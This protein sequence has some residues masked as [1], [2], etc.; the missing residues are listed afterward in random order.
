[1]R[2]FTPVPRSGFLRVF[3]ASLLSFAILVMPFAPV[4][5]AYGNETLAAANSGVEIGG[6][7]EP[8]EPSSNNSAS[9]LFVALPAP[10]LPAPVSATKSGTIVDTNG[11]GNLDPGEKIDYV[12]TLG[13]TSG[14]D[15]T[16][17]VF[18]DT[19]DIH[20][21]LFGTWNSSPLALS[22]TYNAE[23]GVQLVQAAPGVRAN[24]FDPD[25]GNNSG[26]TVTALLDNGGNVIDATAPFTGA[27]AQ[28][29]TV[30]LNADGSFNYTSAVNFEGND[31]FKYRLS[32]GTA[33]DTGTVT[34]KVDKPP[35][36]T[37]TVPANS[38]IN[39]AENANITVN[40]SESVNASVSSF[41]LECPTGTAKT[42]TVS[43]SGTSAITLDPTVDLPPGVICSVTVLANQI[44]DT[45]P[46]DPPDNMAA[47][48]PFSFGVKP[49]AVDD[50]RSATGNI[51]INTAGSG[52]SVLSNDLPVGISVT[53]SDSTS[54]RGGNVTVN[55]NGT[56]TYNPP[57]GYTGADTFNYTIS[58]AAGSDVGTVT[59]NISDMIWFIDD[60]AAACTTISAAAGCGRR[61]NPL[62]TLAAFEAANGN[63]DVPASN[64]YNPAA[65]DHIFIYNGSYPA[66][67]TLENNQRV[68][69]E[70]ATSSLATLTGITL[71]TDSDALPSTGGTKPTIT[72]G[73]NGFNLAQDNQFYGF[74]FSNTTGTAVN[75]NGA[76]GTLIFGDIVINNT[77]NTSGSGISLINGGAGNVT[78]TGINTINTAVATALLVL[79]TNIGSGNLTFRRIDAGN[80]TGD[81]DPV[82]GIQLSS[83]GTT[84]G[85]HGGLI[86]TGSTA[87]NCG[88]V[89]SNPGGGTAATVTAPVSGDC[90][91]G[92]IQGTSGFGISLN[93][94]RGVSL[95]RMWVKSNGDDGI[96]GTTVTDFSLI[97][98]L[99]ESNGNIVNEHGIDMVGLF[100]NAAITN[101]TVRISAENN[102]F[103]DNTSGTLTLLDITGSQF[104]STTA[105]APGADGVLIKPQGTS[106]VTVNV[107]NCFFSNNRDDQ[108]QMAP[109]GTATSKI[110]VNNNTFADSTATTLGGGITINP[111]ANTQTRAIVTN[112]DMTGAVLSAL[113]FN[114]GVGSAVTS[115]FHVTAT[116]NFI[117]NVGVV[118]SGSETGHGI[119]VWGNGSGI[120]NAVVSNNDVRNWGSF[121]GINVAHQDG[122]GDINVTMKDNTV[123]EKSVNTLD[124]IRIEV[125]AVS[126]G[127]IPDA[128]TICADIGDAS[129]ALKN[130]ITTEPNAN[131]DDLRIRIRQAANMTFPGY[132]G[133]ATDAA[134]LQ[135]YLSGRNTLTTVQATTSSTHPTPF[136]NAGAGCT[137]PLTS[138]ENP[139]MIRRGGD[140]AKADVESEDKII[141]SLA[142]GNIVSAVFASVLDNLNRDTQSAPAQN[143]TQPSLLT[144]EAA[145]VHDNT[146][147]GADLNIAPVVQTADT[148]ATQARVWNDIV[149][150]P[151]RAA[152]ASD[153]TSVNA[154][155]TASSQYQASIVKASYAPPANEASIGEKA[156]TLSER[157]L[158]HGKKLRNKQPNNSAAAASVFAPLPSGE[159][160]T[161]NGAGSGFTLPDGKSV[162]ITFQVTLNEPPALS[163][164][165]PPQ[166]SNFGSITCTAGCSPTNTNTVN[167]PVDRYNSSTSV[168]SSSPASFTVD[169]IILTAT[170]VNANV[171]PNPLPPG[172]TTP[173]GTVTFK[174][175][176][177][178]IPNCSNRPMSGG[179]A[180]CNVPAL[181]LAAGTHPITADYSGDGNFDPVT[182]A[183]FNQ[184]VTAC[185]NSITVMNN[186][187]NAVPPVGSLRE[188]ITNICPGGT[189]SFDAAVTGQIN[190]VAALPDL[191]K[192][193]TIAGPGANVLEVR[194]S[195][196]GAGYRVFNISSGVTVNISGL[197]ISNG[198][199][200]L[201]GG[202]INNAGTLNLSN[203]TVKG[204]L[205]TG[206]GAG[207]N[208][209]GT[210]NI[211]GST[212]SNN[213]AT[214]SGGGILNSATGILTLKN[215]T[216]STN[217]SNGGANTGGGISNAGTATLINVTVAANTLGGGINS[218]GT[219][220]L[221]N[222]LIADNTTGS[223]ADIN[224]VFNSNDYNLI[225]NKG[226]ATFTGT[227]AHDQVGTSGA[228]LDAK[229]GPLF[230]NGGP[231]LTHAL[232]TG[233]PAIEAGLNSAATGASLSTD[234]RG[235]GY[236][237]I[238]DSADN[239][240]TQTV[241]IGAFELHPSVE[242][243]P[244]QSAAEDST[245]AI[246]FNVGDDAIGITSVVVTS[247]NTA[248]VLSDNA[249]LTISGAGATRT[250]TITPNAN[251]NSVANGGPTT[252]TVTVTATNGRTAIDTF[253]LTITEVNDAPTAV[254]EAVSNIGEDSG[255]YSIPIATLLGNDSVGP[256]NEAGQTLSIQSVG[257]A[258]GGTVAIN[259]AN[260]EFTPTAN[261][262]GAAGFD[263]VIQDNG[264][265]SGGP[266]AKQD[267]G[268]AT[269]NI[270]A[271]NDTPSF[272]IGA[273]QTV[274]EDA[275][276]QSVSGWATNVTAGAPDE[277]GT[278]T[279]TF[280]VT[281]NTN[282]ALFSTQ[283]A[284]DSSG[285]LTYTPA[286]D[287]SGFADITLTLS[288]NGGGANTSAPQTFKITVTADNDAPSL[289]NNTGITVNEGSTG[290]TIGSAELEV[291]DVDNTAAQLTYTIGTPP[292][293]GTLKK[294]GGALAGGSTFT[295]DD[296][297]NN[298]ITYDHDGSE[299]T[300]DSFTFTVSDG[301]GGSVGG[302]FSITV[303]P[304]NDTPVLAA[305]TVLAIGTGATGTVSNTLLS[306]T[307][308]DNTAAEIT[309][310]VG[311]LP[312]H[313]TL[314]N[315]GVVL[316]GGGT[317]TQADV[318]NNLITY[319]HNG[320]AATTDSF[321]FTADDTDSGDGSIASTT[322]NINLNCAATTVV[323]NTGNSGTGSLREAIA[324][325]C[326]G[327]T[328]TF[329]LDSNIDPGYDAGTNTFTIKLASELV[330]NK[331]LTITGPTASRVIISGEGVTRVFN[332]S[333]GATVAISNLT[334]AN[335]Q[336]NAGGG[337]YNLGNLTISNST[338]TGNKAVGPGAEGGAID[339]EGGTLTIRNSTISGNT[340]EGDGGGVL[341][342]GTSN[343]VLTNVTITNN[344]ANNDN[345]SPGAGGGLAQVSAPPTKVTLKNTIIAGNF[346]GS[347][348]STPDDIYVSPLLGGSILDTSASSN[349]LVGDAATS[350]GLPD[351]SVDAA[352]ANI[353]GNNGAGTINISTVLNTTLAF[354][355]GPTKTHLLAPG[356]PAINAGNNCVL[357]NACTPPPG[358]NLTTDQRGTGFPRNVGTVDIGAVEV[359]YAVSATAGTPQS[360]APNAAFSTQLK[361][362]VTESGNPQ[363]NVS[364]TFTAPAS[365]AS[366]TFPGNVTTTTVS[367]NASGEATAPVFT[368]NG[369]AGGPYNV[370]ASLAGGSP[371]ANFALT[372]SKQPAQVNLSNLVQTFDGLPKPVTVTT[373]PAGLSVVVTYDGSTTVPT[374]FKSGGY[375]VVATVTDP[376]FEGSASATL[377]I[378]KASSTTTISSGNAVY[379]GNP[380]GASAVVTGVGGLNQSLTVTYTGIN[381]TTY[382]PS[383]TAP[384][385]AGEYSA[386]ASFAG[387]TNHLGS[388]D[389]KNYSIVKAGQT[390]NFGALSNK[391]F[392]DADFTV[393]ATASSN[394]AV[395]FGAS[396]QCTV[397][398][399]TVHLT[400]GGSCTIT[401]SQ[402]GN[403]NFNQATNIPQTFQIGAAA[404]TTSVSSSANPSGTGQNVTF[405]ATV[406]SAAGTP[407]GTVQFKVDGTNTGAP[408]ALNASG[409]ATFSIDSLTVGTHAITAD[410]IGNA[411]FTASSG[412]LA[413]GQVVNINTSISINDVSLT[414]GDSGT[415]NFDFTVTLS[416]A[417]NL[418]VKVDFA[419]A[420]G[421]ATVAGSDYQSTTGTLTFIPGD[422]TKT[423]TVQV[424]GDTANEPNET[425]SVNLT[426][427][428][429]TTISDNQGLGTILNDDAP[430]VQF[431]TNTYNV[432]EGI[433]TGFA[434]LT[435][436]RTGD[437]SQALTVDYQ[438]SDQSG[439][440]PC[441]TNNNGFASDRC[442][443]GTA[444][445]TLR[446]AAGEA[447]KTIPV[448]IIN[449]AYV[450]PTEQLTIKLTNPTGGTLGSVDTATLNITDNDTQVATTNPIDDLDFFI[451]MQYADFLGR[452]PDP[453]GFAFWKA[454][455]T[456]NCPA[457]QTCD[458]IDTA[459]RFFGSDEFRE[460]GYFIYL[461]YHA[462]LGRRPTYAEWTMD[463]SKL[464]GYKTVQE[465]EAAKDAFIQEF[466]SRQEFMNL[467]NGSQ[468]GQTFVDTLIQKSGIT[469]ASKQSLINNYA[470][471]GRAATLRAFLETPEV[472]AA[473][474]DR[475]FVTM[476]YFGFL[477]RDAEAGGFAFW[478][479]KLNDSNR[480]YRLLV[481]GFI[482]SDEYRFRYAQISAP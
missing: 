372:N 468:T 19:I 393:S 98:S 270:T 367:T 108:L 167:T 153:E 470:T 47:N 400:G 14:S 414:E 188:A 448:V 160:V 216:I 283:P 369:T 27:S 161:V 70:G 130:T 42:F 139:F 421:T 222:T 59:I 93:S 44:T 1:M 200:A 420:N 317:F 183:I 111:V 90:S 374:S 94:T 83:T 429:N 228:P 351:K 314:F 43:G 419:T 275:G 462:A 50:A 105:A 243:I 191:G 245:P 193:L 406:A 146:A 221:S 223:D 86:V 364:V 32:D 476:L 463:V 435:V 264:T 89:V 385:N 11:D 173:G 390:I 101:S 396:G 209:T 315:N 190:L 195:Q 340:S 357:T 58:N 430:G 238:A 184:Q 257:N 163:Q 265:T 457:G 312:A 474:V 450:E 333:T 54:V 211:T 309:Y 316:A 215:S 263:Y 338:F 324:S 350:G 158:S 168:S 170:V 427:P 229:I 75:R 345:L 259:G 154:G 48:Y 118:Q 197:T 126:P 81:P 187:D 88:G 363:N 455:M 194:G 253:D 198:N 22:D 234:Q 346:T 149:P 356:S 434:T 135:T 53:A 285:K 331:N 387:D 342:C 481:G 276:P 466:M 424:N 217:T 40:F 226:T 124:G 261:F 63:A 120:I 360:A 74:T 25:N 7:V 405:T 15:A 322:F 102:L 206:A 399:N 446:F 115:T 145:I 66:P 148:N 132:I 392:G 332:I 313:G 56:F 49:R 472:Q 397:S 288:D 292:A 205:T 282:T 133:G 411:S 159:T 151:L 251:A 140:L 127:G 287:A 262:N 341:N 395:S 274:I 296:V 125:G 479:Q 30:T 304:V 480:D 201:G 230:N 250:L 91:G 440:T 254:D 465:Q 452:V 300:S 344:R 469:P 439:A 8:T 99:V 278:Q 402:G 380:Q 180:T 31:T 478:M 231:T 186:S 291:T 471:V 28:A 6:K 71:A 55:A 310:T 297:N 459:L 3:T 214:A 416:Q 410:Y 60:S 26:V 441:Q 447:S 169:P 438:T 266:D 73:G 189:I 141:A 165:S 29:G 348:G 179:Q 119:Q 376:A 87:G 248:L 409:V 418:T 428:D 249:H 320:D 301:A 235:P 407:T 412:T 343:A 232:L 444:S 67:L 359:S 36:V 182:S 247:S 267:T 33:T 327:N 35:S 69:G 196:A 192:T 365:G 467:Y 97:S 166:V 475:A 432:N 46:N 299:T 240:D 384:T 185:Q 347:S 213:V 370:T 308:A 218:T 358:A 136:G 378:N 176:G 227:T 106:N 311:T 388:S 237:R 401:A 82:N 353:I 104:S 473:F 110:T 303:T 286:A 460:R 37:T 109:T 21:T 289:V 433:N 329:T 156:E 181:A 123:A 220:N 373:V 103:V 202:G 277:D 306:V 271:V 386:S 284:V 138:L 114:L 256:A 117:G 269:F 305:N 2:R 17:V 426:N 404:S 449:D 78:N 92:T 112:N 268:R 371:S 175:N 294:S 330:I 258:T 337:I 128:G 38:A 225:E 199:D 290:T 164:T 9:P 107:S 210:L 280:N 76:I 144:A 295:Q 80:L 96:H 318:D 389:S 100:G 10:P 436:N 5:A 279:I 13:N 377:T 152:I 362:T 319:T 65:G 79:N 443:Y 116:G 207:I 157:S 442:D 85:T 219:T 177:V 45:D 361:A 422:L 246:I 142:N 383:T 352:R 12:V 445:G 451:F 334:I 328:I 382:G 68:I 51:R 171:A 61:T 335:G 323:T 408:V 208:N 72:S 398:G 255:V 233:S 293:K 212:I 147:S 150:A 354:N 366:G 239:S 24:D 302:T 57:P 273:D 260:V 461:F 456:N 204:N 241:D 403:S 437:I 95:T 391:T 336:S 178:A 458:R 252:I 326:P 355:G 394:L 174:D 172:G 381:G 143:N 77:S 113:N 413:G 122:N 339:S 23:T 62:S 52:F 4:A 121:Y 84:P 34:I 321:T 281:N 375:A 41:Q 203:S 18:N 482:N 20:T 64:I 464:N 454:R 162:T 236:P 477:R 224:G 431:S 415:K 368:A 39:V 298:L 242:D 325:A 425:F 423:V 272:T 417:S 137:Q 131:G 349:N 307:D 134:A 16:G 129:A 379:N 453:A 244:N 155:D